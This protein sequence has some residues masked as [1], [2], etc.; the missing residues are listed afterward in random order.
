MS[1]TFDLSVIIPAVDEGPNLALLLPELCR[2]LNDLGIRYE[3]LIITYRA[4]SQTVSIAGEV[5]ARVIEEHER[6]YGGAL[7]T[8]FASASGLY[9][10]TLDADL[11]HPPMFLYAVWHLRQAADLTIAS[12][13]VPG[14]K[15]HMP[16]IR[17][18]L[19]R[20]LNIVFSRGLS[21]SI[22]DMS[23]GFRLYKAD[24]LHGLLLKA[25]DFDIL[26]EILVRAYLEGWKVQEVPFEYSERKHG[27][28][29][30]R[31]VRF[32]IAYLKTFY[33]LWKLRYSIPTLNNDDCA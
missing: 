24:V 10:L 19:S 21:L 26:Q 13:Y 8:G 17:Y 23:S 33:S 2:V 25:R 5:G 14:G 20:V 7:I 31:L 9:L 15:A 22:R 11:S 29:H 3:I 32:G 6:G 27:Q 30:V 28:S 1:D 16:F 18:F 4:D 12:R